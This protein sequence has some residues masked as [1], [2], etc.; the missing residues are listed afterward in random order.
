[1]ARGRAGGFKAESQ[2]DRYADAYNRTLSLAGTE[3]VHHDVPTGFG[4]THVVE[5]GDRGLPPLVLLHSMSFSSTVWVRN[6]AEFSRHHR[7]LAIDTIGDINLSRSSQKVAGR[8]DYVEWF[9]ALLAHF[10]VA[11]TPIVGNSYGGWLGANVALLRPNLVSS[12][13]LISPSLVFT[14]YKAAFWMHLFSAAFVRSEKSAE[15]FARW[16]VSDPT[17]NDPAAR[18]WLEQFSVGMPFFA[19]MNGFPR[20]VAFTD[21]ELQQL[22]TP[23]LLIEGEDEPMHNP[24]ASISRATKMLGDVRTNLIPGTKHLA[25]LERPERVNDLVLTFLNAP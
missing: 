13:A 24:R 21:G 19:G 22:E 2:R 16:F 11:R 12:L 8:D 18:S 3:L 25:E 7:V 14:K 4:T 17:F 23:V 20:P 1:M 15:R 10:E 5:G 9:T 6:L